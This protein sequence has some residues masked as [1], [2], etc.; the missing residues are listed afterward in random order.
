VSFLAEVSKPCFQSGSGLFF[1][2]RCR[3]VAAARDLHFFVSPKKPWEKK[4]D[5]GACLGFWG[6][7]PNSPSLWLALR[8]GCERTAA[9]SVSDPNNLP[10]VLASGGVGLNSL[11]SNNARPDPPDAPLLGAFTRVWGTDS[12]SDSGQM[13][14]DDATF[15]I[16]ACACNTWA[17][18]LNGLKK[19]R[20]ARFLESEPKNARARIFLPRP[21]VCAKERRARRIRAS[22]CLS[23]ASSS[24][25]PA[26]PSTAGCPQR[27][28]GTQTPGSPFLCLL[29][30][31]EAKE[32]R[33]PTAA[34]ERHRTYQSTQRS[35]QTK[36]S[37]G[38]ARTVSGMQEVKK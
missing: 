14:L 4:G 19:R 6:Q 15:F 1:E 24:S 32:S 12:G 10:A 16:A 23:E 17:R 27:S 33:S 3:S 25:T 30:F 29:S 9:K 37:T 22:D 5:P 2:F 35:I 7:S 38:S 11:R 13:A 18:G 28:G 20:T 36:A 8:V 26:G 34:T 31:G 21:S